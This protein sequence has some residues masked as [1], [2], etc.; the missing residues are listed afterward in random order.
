MSVNRCSL[1][2]AALLL[3]GCLFAP[4]VNAADAVSPQLRQQFEAIMAKGDLF[5]ARSALDDLADH[6]VALFIREVSIKEFEPYYDLAAEALLDDA[7]GVVASAVIALGV[8]GPPLIADQ[9]PTIRSLLDHPDARVRIE[10]CRIAFDLRDDGALPGLIPL[11]DDQDEQV[12]KVAHEALVA[13]ANRNQGHDSQ[14]WQTWYDEWLQVEN[15]VIP[16]L[17]NRITGDDPSDARRAMHT[18]LQLQSHRNSLAQ[19]LADLSATTT[20]QELHKLASSGLQ[21]M[22]DKTAAVMMAPEFVPAQ[23]GDFVPVATATPIAP[24][25]STQAS[26]SEGLSLSQ[27]I[28]ILVLLAGAVWAGFVVVKW[29]KANPKG[30]KAEAKTS[31]KETKAEEGKKR[32]TFTS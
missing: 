1:L 9:L 7:P 13:I 21:M 29:M 19:I 15:E 32:I 30:V 11:V 23:E 22:G 17:V 6:E 16:T 8:I 5:A 25:A 26:S 31:A 18:L 27:I 4:V 20:N 14:S 28:T 10:A 12:R 24:P 3:V 2:P